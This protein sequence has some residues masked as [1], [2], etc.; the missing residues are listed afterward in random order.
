M[1]RRVDEGHLQLAAMQ[2]LRQQKEQLVARGEAVLAEHCRATWQQ[3]AGAQQQQQGSSITVHGLQVECEAGQWWLQA[4]ISLPQQ[5]SAGGGMSLLAA[6]TACGLV[7]RQQ[8]CTASAAS[9]ADS[10]T[11][12]VQL[13][14]MAALDVE[15]QGSPSDAWADVF[16]L[17]ER[18]AGSPLEALISGPA[19]AP[20]VLLGRVQLSWQNWLKSHG[21]QASGR[22]AAVQPPSPRRE[23]RVLAVQS[24]QLDLRCLHQLAQ[25]QLG[26]A[27]AA[28]GP[29]SGDG[30]DRLAEAQVYT[31]QRGVQQGAAPQ[32]AGSLPPPPPAA[33]ATVRITQH[34]RQ[35]AEVELLAGSTHL[36]DV[37][38]Q[39][40]GEGLR[41]AALGA[42][43]PAGN[44]SFEPSLL[45]PRHAQQ[46]AAAAEALVEELDA[47]IH[48]VETLLKEKLALDSQ[49]RRHK[50]AAPGPAA[51]QQA[52]TDALVA[53]AA[54][55]GLMVTLLRG[56]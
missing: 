56:S 39:Q 23:R 13:Q 50:A 53:M 31:L 38:Q 6:S 29:A 28:A 27:P 55:D 54:T 1:R 5:A 34:S 9:G 35:F 40:L 30:A 16:L 14:L 22:Q 52:Q 51:V 21:S 41:Q 42:G 12:S 15:Q 44:A 8:Q 4:H 18:P 48:W 2:R 47:S 33:A 7:C 43:L 37:L 49:Q 3:T 32:H 10:E 11:E 17:E 20:P 36:L 46:T 26:C 24:Q 25:Q 45:S 19:A